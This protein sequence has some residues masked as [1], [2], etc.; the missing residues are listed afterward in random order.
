MKASGI[1]SPDPRDLKGCE[2]LHRRQHPGKTALTQPRGPLPFTYFLN[3][4]LGWR[5]KMWQGRGG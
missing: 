2:C 5:H 3:S 4:T 1:S